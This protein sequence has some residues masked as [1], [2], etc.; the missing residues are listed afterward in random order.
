[1]DKYI[2][3][4]MKN[5]DNFNNIQNSNN[6]LRKFINED[7]FVIDEIN[8]NKNDYLAINNFG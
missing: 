8:F 5:L 3:N 2:L 4:K 1:M 7:L 6:I